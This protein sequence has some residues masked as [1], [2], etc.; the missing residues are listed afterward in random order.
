MKDILL[1]AEDLSLL[2]FSQLTFE[3]T[4]TAAAAL[5]TTAFASIGAQAAKTTHWNESFIAFH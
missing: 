5:S 1:L 3:I 2:L 4:T